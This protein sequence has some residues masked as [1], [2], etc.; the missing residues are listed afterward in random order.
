MGGSCANCG[1]ELPGAY[2]AACGQKRLGEADR[3]FSHLLRQ[4]V[5]TAT[6]LDGRFWGTVRSLLFRPGQLSRDYLAGR[7]ARWM[8]PIA[9]FLLIN[10]VYFFFSG[11]SDFA[12]PFNWE[13]PGRIVLLASDPGTRDAA[14]A[15]RLRDEP[16]PWHS[17]YTAPMV[18]RR[19]QAR[20]AAAR[21]TSDGRR[22]YSYSDYRR[23]YDAKVPEISKTMVIVHMPF[24]AAALM[25]MFWRSRRY[26]AE[27]FVVALHLLAFLMVASLL[28]SRG[29][30]LLHV[31][32]P[33]VD[34]HNTTVNWLIRGVMTLY[35]VLALRCV[36]RVTWYWSIV[37]T[38]G[39][40]LAYILT[41]FLLYRPLLF[42]IAF[43]R[44]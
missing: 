8:S 28:L 11:P 23:A 5:E 1:A 21:A 44:A 31:F 32:V 27:H 39:I 42:M 30:D 13:V 34:W 12:T 24:L 2:C 6:D 41:N 4:F 15:A 17:R 19:V 20:D 29:L 16:G 25:L 26:Y 40:F 7:R 37:A 38:A 18:D 9:L 3:R 35:V 43:A 22:G 10:L 14:E 36:Y 33:R